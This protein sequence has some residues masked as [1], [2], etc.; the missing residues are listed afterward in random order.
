[1]KTKETGS[2]YYESVIENIKGMIVR[3]ELKQG[4]KIPSERELAERFN[5]SRVP[6]RASWTV[7]RETELMF[8]ILPS[9]I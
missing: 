5:V 4:D 6:I 2:R 9:A 3:G 8:A 1:M 7:P